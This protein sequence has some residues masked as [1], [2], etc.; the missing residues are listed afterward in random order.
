MRNGLDHVVGFFSPDHIPFPPEIVGQVPGYF[1][2]KFLPFQK[3]VLALPHELQLV[4]R[5]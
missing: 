1:R 2:Q 5:D 4:N 3:G